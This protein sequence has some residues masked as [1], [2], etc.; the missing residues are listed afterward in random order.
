M[1]GMT[2]DKMTAEQ[3]E[4]K[5]PWERKNRKK[6]RFKKKRRFK[7]TETSIIRILKYL[8]KTS[9]LLFILVFDILLLRIY[10]PEMLFL[11]IYYQRK[12]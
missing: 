9:K 5:G 1:Y 4:I 7:L 6:E 2:S 12:N 10:Y 11:F 3:K 8:K